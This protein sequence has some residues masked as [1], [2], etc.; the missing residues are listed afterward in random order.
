MVRSHAGGYLVYASDLGKTLACQ[1]RGRLKKEGMSIVI[2]DRVELS[3]ISEHTDGVS[4]VITKVCAR[5]NLLSRPP[6]ANVDQVVIV[7]S[8]KPQEWDPYLCDRYL[9]HFQLELRSGKPVL[10]LNKCDIA[11]QEDVRNLQSIYE[12]LGYSVHVVSA[13]T[14]KGVEELVTQ[15]AGKVSVLA[16]PSGVGK[17]SLINR[18]AP[19]L[20]LR[21]DEREDEFGFGHHVT[22]C[23]ELYEISIE[24]V[25]GKKISEVESENK[26][27]LGD[28]PGFRISE[29]THPEP[30][31]VAN[32]YPEIAKLAE[33]CKFAD[34]LHTIE[35]DCNVLANLS[36]IAPQRYKSYTQVVQEA[37]NENKLQKGT[38]HKVESTIKKV[39]RKQG[40][41]IILP[42]LKGEYRNESRRK[43]IQSL[44]DYT[45]MKSTD[46][47][48][49][50]NLDDQGESNDDNAR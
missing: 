39:G 47:K 33:N 30:V 7:Q 23:S 12:P 17:S 18:I 13:L 21:V 3:E 36:H 6:I 49:L 19:G 48:E 8:L 24:Q 41:D 31:D 14:G 27:W 1:A 38:P 29:L 22:T 10:C 4:A 16:G 44:K 26:Y 40:K 35:A 46:L 28:S 2:G 5:Q 32:Q 25:T 42:K 11:S 43:N 34:C 45:K 37:Q 50:R 9:V 20:D 15:L